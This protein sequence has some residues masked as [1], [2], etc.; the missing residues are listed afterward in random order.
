MSIE[1]LAQT[2][3]EDL[4]DAFKV[5]VWW[6]GAEDVLSKLGEDVGYPWAG[7]SS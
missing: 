1:K 4:H 3:E 5:C 6:G 7:L 2:T